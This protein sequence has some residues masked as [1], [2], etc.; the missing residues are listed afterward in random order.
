MEKHGAVI[1]WIVCGAKVPTRS[2]VA[3]D[4]TDAVAAF[5]PAR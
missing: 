5:A 4:Q 2:P 1:P 3:T